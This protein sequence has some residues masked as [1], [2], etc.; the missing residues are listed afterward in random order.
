MIQIQIRLSHNETIMEYKEIYC[1]NCKKT[2]GKYNVK[3]YSDEKIA[4]L[5]KISHSS[6]I[7]NGH[8]VILRRI[9]DK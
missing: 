9:D 6:H 7:R 2:L 3:Y 1:N 8:E 5:M 4:E